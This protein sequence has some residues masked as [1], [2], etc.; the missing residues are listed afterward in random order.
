MFSDDQSQSVLESALRNY[1]EA[2]AHDVNESLR[3][4]SVHTFVTA[5]YGNRGEITHRCE[6]CFCRRVELRGDVHYVTLR[7]DR[8]PVEPS[9]V[10]LLA[11]PPST[12]GEVA[13]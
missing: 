2:T 7:G 9:C 10:E 5:H 11:V 1:A 4:T 8:L 6:R 13:S 12:L 3:A